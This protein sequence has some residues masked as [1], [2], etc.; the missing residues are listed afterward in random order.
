MMVQ[1]RIW[2]NQRVFERIST[3]LQ[4]QIFCVM[5]VSPLCCLVKE[6]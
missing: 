5:A 6:F 4:G 1:S 2:K 3:I